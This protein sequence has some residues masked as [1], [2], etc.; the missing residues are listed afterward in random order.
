MGKSYW[1]NEGTDTLLTEKEYKELIER[2]AKEWLEDLR[3]DEEELDESDKT[4]LETL[5]QLSYEN[6]SDF[7]LSDNEGNK[8]E[9]W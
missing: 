4:S 3:E 6:E 9:E 2:E 5:I 1:Y 8:L 7:V